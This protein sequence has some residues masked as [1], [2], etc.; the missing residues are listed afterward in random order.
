[1]PCAYERDSLESYLGICHAD[2]TYPC[3]IKWCSIKVWR[4]RIW[5]VCGILMCS[6]SIPYP[7]IKWRKVTK[8]C[9]D[10]SWTG[11]TCWGLY[12]KHYG[13][14]DGKEYRW[15]DWCLG[16]SISDGKVRPGVTGD[17]A[18]TVTVCFDEDPEELGACR[19][20]SSIPNDTIIPSGFQLGRTVRSEGISSP[21]MMPQWSVV[22]RMLFRK[23]GQCSRCMGASFA[24]AGLFALL[25][26]SSA[27]PGHWGTHIILFMTWAFSL[28]SLGH[29]LAF[30]IRGVVKIS[31]ADGGCD[32]NR[33]KVLGLHRIL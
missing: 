17:Y 23:L 18:P 20:G 5:Y 14:C 2:F 16:F 21:G 33:G 8:S 19:T 28:L 29:A 27:I 31:S 9:Y 1:M 30:I 6:G 11:S 25:Y 22:R 7:C 24:G 32:C 3:G 12:E 13:C 4:I 26:E 15:T 10:F